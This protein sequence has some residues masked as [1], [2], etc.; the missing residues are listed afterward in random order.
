MDSERGRKAA[1]STP[2]ETLPGIPDFQRPL[3]PGTTDFAQ[4][5]RGRARKSGV[6]GGLGGG[7][8]GVGVVGD[9]KI[10]KP[11]TTTNHQEPT[12]KNSN[13]SPR[14]WCV[15][16]A[17]DLD[18]AHQDP[19][20]LAY[21]LRYFLDHSH[22][23]Q[24][25]ERYGLELVTAGLRELKMRED[26]TNPP[27]WL[28]WKVRDLLVNGILDVP[29]SERLPAIQ[30]RA[31]QGQAEQGSSIPTVSGD[32]DPEAVELWQAV[33]DRMR[34]RIPHSAVETYLEPTIGHVLD[35]D[36]LIV[37]V[38]DSWIADYLYNRYHLILVEQLGAE[39]GRET[40]VDFAMREPERD[41]E[42]PGD[43]LEANP[44]H[45]DEP[46]SNPDSSEPSARPFTSQV[47]SVETWEVIVR[48]G[49][50][51]MDRQS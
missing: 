47:D 5:S 46:S 48:V 40:E 35:G 37:A 36:T 20:A 11:P 51:E 34:S 32:P 30:Q 31:A 2:I 45:E 9:I 28:T 15:P 44:E 49:H 27:G 38:P 26:V 8:V 19:A 4:P 24:F 16:D 25:I 3:E 7:G 39:R 33:I 17:E 12:T 41:F 14:D 42:L 6:G 13:R 1:D 21:H 29:P 10:S 22:P 23:E 18:H 50:R 43:A